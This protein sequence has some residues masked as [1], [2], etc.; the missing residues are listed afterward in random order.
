MQRKIYQRWDWTFSIMGKLNGFPSIN[1]MIMLNKFDTPCLLSVIS[2][3][4][5]NS[6]T[7]QNKKNNDDTKMMFMIRM[8]SEKGLH[9]V[10]MPY[11]SGSR[12]S[13]ST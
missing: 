7:E 11:Y 3:Y 8:V 1:A 6:T 10:I 4:L 12:S 9:V 2:S 13:T 5:H